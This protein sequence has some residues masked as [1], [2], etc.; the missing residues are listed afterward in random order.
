L[1]KFQEAVKPGGH[2]FLNSSLVNQEP[3][4]N[5]IQVVKIPANHI[6][7]QA[8]DSRVANLAMLGAFVQVTGLVSPDSIPAA[9]RRVIPQRRHNLI[10]INQ[11]AFEQGAKSVK[12]KR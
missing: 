1:P 2:L 11:K 10:P 4:R 3:S 9:L 6:A 12:I 7:E 5:D 8:G